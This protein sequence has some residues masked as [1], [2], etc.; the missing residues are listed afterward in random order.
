MS[1]NKNIYFAYCIEKELFVFNA[2]KDRLSEFGIDLIRVYLGDKLQLCKEEVYNALSLTQLVDQKCPIIINS[3]TET[4][5]KINIARQGRNFISVSI[6]HGISP[7][8]EYSHKA[9]HHR[10][11][12]FFASTELI[13][14]RLKNNSPNS[15][16]C[17]LSGYPPL[18]DRKSSISNIDIR[19][20]REK[21][22]YGSNDI[23]V[24]LAFSWDFNVKSISQ[25]PDTHG[26][27]I[28]LHPDTKMTGFE[29]PLNAKVFVSNNENLN[30]IIK[31]SDFHIG[32]VSSI[33]LECA[34]LGFKTLMVVDH[35]IYHNFCDIDPNFFN[36]LHP[37][38]LKISG[39]NKYLESPQ[40]ISFDD[41]NR[42]LTSDRFTDLK[43][44]FDH[45]T[46]LDYGLPEILPNPDIDTY[47]IISTVLFSI[48]TT[49]LIQDNELDF[50][51]FI[52]DRLFITFIYQ[53]VLNRDPDQIGLNHYLSYLRRRFDNPS[54]KIDVVK[55]IFFEI[56]Q[57]LE[58]KKKRIK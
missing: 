2:L 8:K 24:L 56:S 41:L 44:R 28:V 22:G 46:R 19:L 29:K 37:S 35:S 23:I 10:N 6:E 14:N 54:E 57:S 53:I 52:S 33:T 47:S 36:D 48:V 26:I 16:K 27:V 25:I 38:Y 21:Y 20:T 13:A 50:D 3:Y 42:L 43:N 15:F 32:D 51:S 4:Y 9:E 7:F 31:I 17:I 5:D 55:S 12:Y 11:Q 34:A 40:I 45:L 58:A 39:T 1:K 18:L 49:D 30:E